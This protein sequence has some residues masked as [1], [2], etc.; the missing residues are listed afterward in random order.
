[1]PNHEKHTSAEFQHEI[2]GIMDLV[3]INKIIEKINYCD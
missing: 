3:L 2:I 1:M